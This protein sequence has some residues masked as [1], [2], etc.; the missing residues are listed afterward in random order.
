MPDT[1]SLKREK[2]LS[3]RLL[4][5]SG[6]REEEGLGLDHRTAEGAVQGKAERKNPDYA[7]KA[8]CDESKLEKDGRMLAKLSIHL[9]ILCLQMPYSLLNLVSGT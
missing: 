9:Q 6:K 7:S 4:P 8:E 1:R 5:S 2:L 3:H